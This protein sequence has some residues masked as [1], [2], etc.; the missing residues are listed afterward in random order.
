MAGAGQVA[1]L[2]PVDMGKDAAAPGTWERC[3]AGAWMPWHCTPGPKF[4]WA[5]PGA[6]DC[7]EDKQQRPID[8]AWPWAGVWPAE[9]GWWESGREPRG[10][11]FN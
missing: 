11:T 6:L 10:V 3:G 2:C 1:Q 7:F 4:F 5:Q 9:W 8:E